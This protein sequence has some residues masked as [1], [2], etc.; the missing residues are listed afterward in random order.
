MCRMTEMSGACGCSDFDDDTIFVGSDDNEYIFISGFEIAKLSTE[1]EIIDFMSLM[2]NNMILTAIAIAQKNT[3]FMSDHY[4]FIENDKIEEGTL[5]NF[6][7]DSVD[8]QDYHIAKCGEGASKTMECNQIHSFQPI[9]ESEEEDEVVD[10]WR[11]QREF[12]DCVEEQRNLDK[13]SYCN[14]NNQMVKIF[15]QKCVM[16]FENPSGYAF[17]QCGHQCK[18]EIVGLLQMLKC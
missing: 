13:S 5:L 16:C 15:N 7:N 14:R 6:T 11:A 9:E 2:G 12:D 8:P 18:C 3:Y 10:T 1:D 4:K 17:R